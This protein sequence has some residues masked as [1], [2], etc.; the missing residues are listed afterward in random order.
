[1]RDIISF[2][3]GPTPRLTSFVLRHSSP[4]RHTRDSTWLTQKPSRTFWS[5]EPGQRGL[6]DPVVTGHYI[7]GYPSGN[8]ADSAAGSLDGWWTYLG[9]PLCFVAAGQGSGISFGLPDG[10]WLLLI[11]CR[12]PAARL[13]LEAFSDGSTSHPLIYLQEGAESLYKCIISAFSI[14][15]FVSLLSTYVR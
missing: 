9:R 10:P 1:M 3:A 6:A 2:D 7:W 11:C 8:V 15:D 4:Y 14:L 12:L 13:C 5:K